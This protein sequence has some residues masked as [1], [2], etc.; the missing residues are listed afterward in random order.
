MYS[1]REIL[2]VSLISF[3]VATSIG[4]GFDESDSP[5][6][7]SY[8]RYQPVVDEAVWDVELHHN[9]HGNETTVSPTV[10]PSSNATTISPSPAPSV[11]PTTAEPT[12]AEP[13]TSPPTTTPP[14][15]VP[16]TPTP[17]PSHHRDREWWINIFKFLIKT[18]F[19][20]FVA[21]LFFFVFGGI[22]SNRY[23]IYY[24]L[25]G[26]WYSLLRKLKWPW[27]SGRDGSAPSSTLNDIIFS[28]N[29]LQEG[30]LMRET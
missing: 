29:D 27:R 3:S 26:S 2:L 22:M 12:T 9:S 14:T 8:L 25:R 7:N 23:R 13:T 11:A 16:P 20:I 24:Y 17:S 4:N 18:V 1:I 28:D 19:W 10:A 15:S 21:V 6:K 5:D 30:L